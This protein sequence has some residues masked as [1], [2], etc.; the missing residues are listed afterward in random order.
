MKIQNQVPPDH[1]N[2][3]SFNY[4]K[5]VKLQRIMKDLYI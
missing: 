1:T 4:A 5:T 2:L 3:L